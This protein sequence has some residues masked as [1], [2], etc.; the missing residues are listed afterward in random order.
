MRLH[1]VLQVVNRLC[2]LLCMTETAPSGVP[3][4]TLGDRLAK[5]LA[6]S[7]VSHAEMADFLEVSRNTVG[8][9]IAGRVK[10]PAATLRVWADKTGVSLDWLRTG[11]VPGGPPS[12]GPVPPDGG[13]KLRRLTARKAARTGRVSDNRRYPIAA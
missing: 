6:H 9:Y 11:T 2:I 12:R 10:V 3:Q 1:K 8:N 7:D 5:S 13:E 4:W